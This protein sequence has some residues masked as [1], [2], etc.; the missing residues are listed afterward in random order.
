MLQATIAI[1][2]SV[3]EDEARLFLAMKLFEVGRLSCGQAAELSGYSKLTFVE[4]L[5]RHGVPVLDYPADELQDDLA[6]A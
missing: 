4:L 3:T 1:P 6:N 5:A 2:D